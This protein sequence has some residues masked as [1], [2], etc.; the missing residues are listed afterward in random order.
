M[1]PALG[2]AVAYLLGSIPAA[3]IAGKA[4]MDRVLRVLARKTKNNPVLL[5]EPGVGAGEEHGTV[6]ERVGGGEPLLEGG[7]RVGP[8]RLLQGPLQLSAIHAL[9][10]TAA[11]LQQARLATTVINSY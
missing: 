5:G 8:V 4:G 7:A 2:I 1:H 9:K 3:Y 11:A 6:E 10:G